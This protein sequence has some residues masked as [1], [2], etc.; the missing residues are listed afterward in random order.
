MIGSSGWSFGWCA[1]GFA[2]VVG[3][4]EMFWRAHDGRSGK[5][6]AKWDSIGERWWGPDGY[7]L[8][9][10]GGVIEVMVNTKDAVEN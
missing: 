8:S 10:M 2:V 6:E 7:G 1:D 9:G 4:G 3:V 5:A